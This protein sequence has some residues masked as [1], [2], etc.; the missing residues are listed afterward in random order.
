MPVATT[1]EMRDKKTHIS[2]EQ[3]IPKKTKNLVLYVRMKGLL[4][5]VLGSGDHAMLSNRC[6]ARSFFC[7][8]VRVPHLQGKAERGDYKLHSTEPLLYKVTQEVTV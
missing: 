4:G 2:C 6:T 3:R 1:G 5:Q 8:F 7:S